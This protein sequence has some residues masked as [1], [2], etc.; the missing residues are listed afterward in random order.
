MLKKNEVSPPKK[1]TGKWNE[2]P[3]SEQTARAS[4]DCS[5]DSRR[6]KMVCEVSFLL[7]LFCISL[8]F[9]WH[10]KTEYVF[11]Y[12]HF[13][14]FVLGGSVVNK[15]V[16]TTNCSIKVGWRSFVQRPSLVYRPKSTRHG[17]WK[18]HS[19]CHAITEE[20]FLI[21]PLYS[22]V[23]S[24]LSP[25]RPPS[26]YI[27]FLFGSLAGPESCQ[28]VRLFGQSCQISATSAF[29][30]SLSRQ[31]WFIGLRDTISLPPVVVTAATTFLLGQFSTEAPATVRNL[32][33]SRRGSIKYALACLSKVLGAFII[34]FLVFLNCL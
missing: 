28:L 17:Q 27:S 3:R 30:Y 6:R 10:L 8:H 12:H 11:F 14:Y 23:Y 19:D 25:S 5:V 29:E 26:P 33:C 9:F 18:A 22:Y 7:K 21:L 16:I 1:R 32:L 24:R 31:H 13:L 2:F 34:E 20:S 15:A 4:F